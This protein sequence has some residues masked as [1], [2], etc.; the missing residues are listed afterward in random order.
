MAGAGLDTHLAD[1]DG[2]RLA[3]V[4]LAAVALEVGPQFLL[5]RVLLADLADL[6][7][8][9]DRDAGRFELADQGGQLGG[10]GVVH[11]LLIVDRRLREIDQ[12]GAVD[13]DVEVARGDRV[14]ARLADLLGDGLRVRRVLLGVELVVVALDE[15]GPAP[16]C[17][18]R[19]GEHVRR[20]F[21][22]PLVGVGL[23]RTRQLEDDR[24]DAPGD[25]RGEDRAGHVEGLGSQVDRR[26]GE[27]RDLAACPRRVQL[28]D[29]RG[30]HAERLARLPDQPAGRLDGRRVGRE[31]LRPG[32][33]GDGAGAERCLVGDD[34]AISLDPGAAIEQA[35][36]L[37]DGRGDGGHGHWTPLMRRRPGQAAPARS[38]RRWRRLPG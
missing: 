10:A 38:P 5:V 4:E 2:P 13:V 1:A 32:Q 27:A 19:P 18:D 8:D 3:C 29:A 24:A 37:G 34:E 17:R 21:E 20:V 23:L 35:H 7:A 15:D 26:D 33:V 28:L 22:D 6:A 31:R 9:A 12:R 36:E 16:A 30:S 25:G 14:P 11:A